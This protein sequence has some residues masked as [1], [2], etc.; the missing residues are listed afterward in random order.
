MKHTDGQ[1]ILKFYQ[2][3]NKI[4]DQH[5]SKLVNLIVNYYDGD[6]IPPKTIIKIVDEI[7][8]EFPNE[9]R[10]KNYI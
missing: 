2:N 10:V 1:A 5:R 3:N 8:R 7:V 9:N 6:S 4:L